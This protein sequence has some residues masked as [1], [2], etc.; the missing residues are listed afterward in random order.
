MRFASTPT[1][2]LTHP[3]TV[4]EFTESDLTQ[5]RSPSYLQQLLSSVLVFSSPVHTGNQRSTGVGR[6]PPAAL[7]LLPSGETSDSSYQPRQQ[8]HREL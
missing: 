2:P 7:H 3:A 1:L 6:S 4:A 8:P 5:G